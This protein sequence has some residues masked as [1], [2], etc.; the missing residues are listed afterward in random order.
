M[1]TL[2]VTRERVWAFIVHAPIITIIWGSYILCT[3]LTATEPLV[4]VFSKKMGSLHSLPIT[5][6]LFTFMTIPISLFVY[7]MQQRS[8]FV[9]AHA[10]QAYFFNVSLLQW[11]ACCLVTI[12]L[13]K[14]LSS[15]ALVKA[16]FL[17]LTFASANCF[18]QAVLAMHAALMGK[19][20]Q[21]HF[22]TKRLLWR[23]SR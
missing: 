19:P 16:G 2:I 11:Y 20:F 21:Y 5:P 4:D 15:P 14:Y 12:M 8:S 17:I 6:L 9:K 3:A 7:R 22:I 18:V 13:G 23:H 10:T 1:T